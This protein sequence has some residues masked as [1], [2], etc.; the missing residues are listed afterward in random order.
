MPM[1][2]RSSTISVVVPAR[3]EAKNIPFVFDNLPL[4]V[5]EVILVDGNSVD[6]TIAVAERVR[7]DVKVVRQVRRGKGN[8]LAAGFHAATGDYIVMIDADGSMHPAEIP[9]FVAALDEGAQY[10]KGTRF[11]DG[12]GSDDI[13]RLR[14][15]G[16]KF[17]NGST[18]LLFKTRFS[19]LCYGYNAFRRECLEAFALPDPH[20]TSVEA[21]WGDGFEIETLINVRA[22]KAKLVIAEVA[23]FEYRRL[24]G[25]S[26]LRTFRDGTR[27]LATILKERVTSSTA[28]VKTTAKIEHTAGVSPIAH[29][30]AE[31][32][33][34]AQWASPESEAV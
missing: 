15:M 13:S 10:A 33:L 17:L 18:N 14:D 2:N 16:N 27:V 22:A 12:G 3:N 28:G 6:D 31:R 25:E 21:H 32:R 5:D 4:G 11:A 7:P 1:S 8:A 24:S 20:D 34:R 9:R 29:L 30:D 23:S 26:N 19:D